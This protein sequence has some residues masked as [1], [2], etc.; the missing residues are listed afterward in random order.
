MWIDYWILILK[1]ISK[2]VHAQH[3]HVH[4]IAAEVWFHR[5]PW[6]RSALLAVL[7]PVFSAIYP[8]CHVVKANRHLCFHWWEVNSQD[9]VDVQRIQIIVG[10][11]HFII[12]DISYSKNT[13]LTIKGSHPSIT[14]HCLF[15]VFN[16]KVPSV[17]ITVISSS[18]YTSQSISTAGLCVG[19]MWHHL[20]LHTD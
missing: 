14:I 17:F 9:P 13:H 6:W 20:Q 2:N 4:K 3:A 8:C 12:Y 19:I 5:L 18:I 16:P 10:L 7:R 15:I 1:K 11:D